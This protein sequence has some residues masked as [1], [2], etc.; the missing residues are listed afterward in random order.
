LLTSTPSRSH[1]SKA[2][3]AAIGF[4]VVVVL[5]AL[6]GVGYA[7][8][9]GNANPGAAPATGSSPTS[10]RA[11]TST[12]P[13]ASAPP[14]APAADVVPFVALPIGSPPNAGAG[15][16]GYGWR[17]L[18]VALKGPRQAAAGSTSEFTVRLSNPTSAAIALTP[19]P[20]FDLSVGYQDTSY[21]LN[22]AGAPTSVIDPGA[23][24]TFA[25]PVPV[26]HSLGGTTTQVSFSL[27]WQTDKT[28]PHATATLKVTG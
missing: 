8:T 24:M 16:G 13:Q 21:G 12:S 15:D 5:A 3:S 26:A 18:A 25:M 9:R 6:A 27:G 11:S 23:S 14:S 7:V 2:R 19:C 22:C 1:R 10:T 4:V 20:A 28:S 17:R